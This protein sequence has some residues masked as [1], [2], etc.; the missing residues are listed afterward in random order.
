MS[1][2][3]HTILIVEDEPDAAWLLVHHLQRR[4][5][6]VVVA[7]DGRAVLNAAFSHRPNLVLLDLMLPHLHGYEVCR[8]LKSS[9]L[10]AHIP[11]LMLTALGGMDDKLRGFKLGADDYVT[12]PYE[13]AELMARVQV[14]LRRKPARHPLSQFSEL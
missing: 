8:L 10:T 12:K 6:H 11:I 5:Y 3:S 1:D 9:S 7:D 13:I 4:G 2:S 14:L